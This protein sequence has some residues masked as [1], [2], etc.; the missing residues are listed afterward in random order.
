MAET[1]VSIPFGSGVD[2]KTDPKMVSPP[3]TILIQDGIFTNRQRVTK[4]NGYTSMTNALVG[5]GT[6]SSPT[7]SKS[8]QDELLLAATTSSGQRLLSYSQGLNAWSDRGKYLSIAVSKQDIASI[9]QTVGAKPTGGTSACSCAVS[10]NYQLYAYYTANNSKVYMAV[11]DSTTG[12]HL[13]TSSNSLVSTN[14]IN[15]KTVLLGVSTLGIVYISGGTTLV[16]SIV[17]V[18]S[19]GVVVGAPITIASG[20]VISTFDVQTTSTGAVIGYYKSGSG[21]VSLS[22]VDTSGAVLNTASIAAAGAASLISLNVDAAG[23]IWVYWPDNTTA[24]SNILY[25]AVFSS[26]LASVLAKTSLATGLNRVNNITA[27]NASTT[28]QI[29]YFSTLYTDNITPSIN[30]GTL[31]SAGVVGSPAVYLNNVDIY[32]KITALGGRNYMAV[33]FTSN[34]TPTGIL[35]DTSD[36]IPVAKFLPDQ[37]DGIVGSGS[38]TVLRSMGFINNLISLSSSKLLLCS[39]YVSTLFPITNT[40]STGLVETNDWTT[41]STAGITFDFNN[42]DAYQGLVQDDAL[43][44]NGGL[45]YQYDHS[46]VVELGF[47][48]DPEVIGSVSSTGGTI[49]TGSWLYYTTYE[50]LDSNGNLHESAPS[51]AYRAV[52]ASGSTNSVTILAKSYTATQ[53]SNVSVVLWKTTSNGVIAYRS[54]T[55]PNDPTANYVS[56]SDLGATSDATLQSNQPLYT[57]GGAILENI[58]PPPSMIIWSNLNRLWCVDSENPETTIE[59]S[60]TASKGT[61]I[62]FSTGQLELI[63]DSTYGAITGASKL[64]EKTVILKAGGVGYFYGDGANDAGTGSS[65]T[66]LQFIPSD[67]GCTNSKSVILYPDGILYRTPKG[68]YLVSRKI[69]TS[70][71]G[72][73]VEAYNSQDIQS[74]FIVPDKQQIRF[75][76]SSGSSLLYDYQFNQWSVFT[77]HTGYSA[78]SF[79]GA[80]VYARVDGSVYLENKTSFLDN[81]T[82]Y[83]PLLQLSWIKAT[84]IQG[85]QRCRR[86]ALLGDFQGAAGHGVQISVA[87]DFNPVFTAPV[88]YYFSGS[89]GVYQYRE[90]LSQQ[91]CDSFQL[92]IQEITT[93]A[94]GEFIDFSDLGLEIMAKTGLN[95]LPAS[96]TVG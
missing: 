40:A 27:I 51:I 45:V 20:A 70:Y 18:T 53:K 85:F 8:Y 67:A 13:E 52:F 28:Q 72:T 12:M 77:N 39:G 93:G 90:R 58:A 84:S 14:A 50:W 10:G 32:S 92:K 57:Q 31:T 2:T 59:Y 76:T 29:F 75:L 56:F 5:G 34:L 55:Q 21:I 80:Y 47:T 96:Q 4:R 24:G 46:S 54:D 26:V 19:G 73:D 16:L 71:F 42:I 60:K 69:Q 86:V 33:V 88:P 62:S 25:G 37:A 1:T 74:A 15:P 65:I 17:T 49:A 63:I 66:P 30:R 35:I 7:M 22:T 79:G 64:D 23:Q 87:Y 91:K 83:A 95:K 11:I 81:T 82:P 61:G 41:I 68:I 94:S 38:G 89:N 9:N 44:L 3:K 78:T 36:G 48:T 6:W 43:I